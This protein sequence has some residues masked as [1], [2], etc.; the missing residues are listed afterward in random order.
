M[1]PSTVISLVSS[2]RILSHTLLQRD[3][4]DPPRRN[5]RNANQQ[6]RF[7]LR[8]GFHSERTF[9]A[10]VCSRG[11][12]ISLARGVA[13]R[14]ARADRMAKARAQAIAGDASLIVADACLT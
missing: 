13:G 11:F 6:R 9:L 10:R 3:V 12:L 14:V 7:L 1:V 8:R 5:N 2:C 4:N